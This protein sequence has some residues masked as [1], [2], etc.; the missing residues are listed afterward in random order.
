[1]NP[2]VTRN[3]TVSSLSR[4]HVDSPTRDNVRGSVIELLYPIDAHYREH[5]S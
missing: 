3:M 5:Y 2:I 4:S 1:M